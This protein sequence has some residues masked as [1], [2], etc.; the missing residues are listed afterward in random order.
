MTVVLSL[1]EASDCQEDLPSDQTDPL[2]VSLGAGGLRVGGRAS[3]PDAARNQPDPLQTPDQPTPRDASL[4]PSV[5]IQPADQQAAAIQAIADQLAKMQKEAQDFHATAARDREADCQEMLRRTA[6][7]RPP[8]PGTSQQDPPQSSSRLPYPPADFGV[9]ARQPPPYLHPGLWRALPLSGHPHPGSPG[10]TSG[11]LLPDGDETFLDFIPPQFAMPSAS[12][13]EEQL[14]RGRLDPQLLQQFADPAS[15]FRADAHSLKQANLILRGVGLANPAT[16]GGLNQKASDNPPPPPLSAKWPH[17][18]VW[19][20][21]TGHW[22]DT[23]IC[24]WNN[25]C[26]NHTLDGTLMLHCCA[27][28]FKHGKHWYTHQET[29]CQRRGGMA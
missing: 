23:T 7:A 21:K 3:S 12:I 5:V 2:P 9:P 6:T 26:K 17:K 1:L 19:L 18:K 4:Q 28:C 20:A 8:T 25:S 22:A 10:S 13:R 16:T 27:Y 24:P 11:H 15:A 14:S 29:T